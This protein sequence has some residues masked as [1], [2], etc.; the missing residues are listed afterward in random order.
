[1]L[2]IYGI[3]ANQMERIA[4]EGSKKWD[5]LAITDVP[6]HVLSSLRPYPHSPEFHFISA[7][8]KENKYKYFTEVKVRK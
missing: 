8:P 6:E 7:K 3:P 2:E 4:R 5:S 1:M